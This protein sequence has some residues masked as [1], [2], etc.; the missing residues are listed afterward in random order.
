M[1]CVNLM[2]AIIL[3]FASIYPARLVAQEVTATGANYADGILVTTKDIA[4]CP[5]RVIGSVRV[6]ASIEF[7]ST[8]EASLFAKI[9]K[10]GRSLGADAVVMVTISDLRMTAFSFGKR[11]AMGRAIQYIDKSCAPRN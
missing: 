1:K 11:D 4:N 8:S 5:Y 10:K 6:S 2:A 7:S 9:R 3:P